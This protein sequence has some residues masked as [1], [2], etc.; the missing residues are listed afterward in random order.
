MVSD[1]WGDDPPLIAESD[2]P[3]LPGRLQ[4]LASLSGPTPM[5]ELGEDPAVWRT[6]SGSPSA[7]DLVEV[8]MLADRGWAVAPIEPWLRFLPGVAGAASG[9]DP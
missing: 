9:L 1:P 7:A 4:R 8:R 6:P 3:P 2:L 5:S